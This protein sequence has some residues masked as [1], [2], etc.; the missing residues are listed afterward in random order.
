MVTESWNLILIDKLREGKKSIAS[1]DYCRKYD[2]EF[3]GLN[4]ICT[5]SWASG[6]GQ[7]DSGGPLLQDGYQIGI[8]SHAHRNHGFSYYHAF[9]RVSRYTDWIYGAM[10]QHL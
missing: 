6:M 1:P 2:A 10:S 5:S 7:G 9:T 8:A 4:T 3:S